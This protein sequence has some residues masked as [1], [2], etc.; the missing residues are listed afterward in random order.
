MYKIEIT[1]TVVCE[2]TNNGR[3]FGIKN[4]II[5]EVK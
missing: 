4:R 5:E 2:D 1:E 3:R